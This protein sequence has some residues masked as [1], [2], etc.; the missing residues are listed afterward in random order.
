MSATDARA[1]IDALVQTLSADVLSLESSATM[2]APIASSAASTLPRL[3]V[4]VQP[5]ASARG[6]SE[7]ELVSMLGAGGMG[8][9][10]LARQ[11]SLDREV[12]VKRLGGEAWSVSDAAA[13]LVEARATGALEHPGIVPVHALGVSSDGSPMLVMKRVDGTTLEA[14]L[15]DEAHAAWS[16]LERRHG[17]RLVACIEILARVAD[18]LELAHA[19]GWIHRDVK[20]ANVMVGAFGETYL[21]D[22]GIATR[23]EPLASESERTSIV[24][25]PAYMAPEMIDGRGAVDPRT[26]VYLLGAT[27][28][29]VLTKTPR[30]PGETIQAV[31]LSAMLS[32]PPTYDAAV[33]TELADLVRRSTARDRAERPASAAAFREALAEYLRHRGSLRLTRDVEQKLATITDA[34]SAAT[35]KTITEVRFGLTH[36]LREWPG[37]EAAQRALEQA[38]RLAIDVEL[39]RGSPEAAAA[40]FAELAVPDDAL[41]ARIEALRTDVAR[42]EALAEDARRD[43]IERDPRVG[44]RPRALFFLFLMIASISV[45][46]AYA[47]LTGAFMPDV[48]ASF[49]ADLVQFTILFAIIF[50]LRKRLLAN[51]FGRRV[52]I[53]LVVAAIVVTVSGATLVLRHGTLVDVMIERNLIFAGL[54]GVMAP[55]TSRAMWIASAWGLAA[56]ILGSRWPLA[57]AP[58]TMGTVLLPVGILMWKSTR[59]SPDEAAKRSA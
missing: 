34:T 56:A 45:T 30:H 37:N 53:A 58:L 35:A 15:H 5:D 42:R 20:P 54:F 10:W 9:V 21:L 59:P 55:D 33:P 39:A 11:R 14:L 8:Q 27:L 22:W 52:I 31:L 1:K 16:A 43:A 50:L 26:D 48:G 57:A 47:M 2:R 23:T 51:R 25:T 12:A 32:E 3:D 38:L 13:L 46:A 7:L 40:I 41:R 4:A 49:G 24:G 17:D 36:A 18:A 28:H 19:R 44:G 29:A 6:R